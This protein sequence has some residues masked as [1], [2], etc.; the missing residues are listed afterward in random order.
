MKSFYLFICLIFGLVLPKSQVKFHNITFPYFET[1][2]TVKPTNTI[3]ST[4]RLTKKLMQ[5]VEYN[6]FGQQ[7]GVTIIYRNDGSP[8]S[9]NYYHNGKIVYQAIPFQ[10]SFNI[11]KV[12]N[13]NDN[14]NFDGIQSYTYLNNDD[15]KWHQMN[16]T[17]K[18]GRLTSINKEINLPEYIIN[19]DE[20]KLNGN[21]YFYDNINCNCYYYGN[22]TNGKINSI[23]AFDINDD[24]TF[25]ILIYKL[26]NNK[27]NFTK[28]NDFNNPKNGEIEI[29]QN[30]I[31]IENN[32]IKTEEGNSK[33]VFNKQ[34]NW[35]NILNEVAT[36]IEIKNIEIEQI[37]YSEAM[38]GPPAPYTLPSK[39]N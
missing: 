17:F 5:V 12:F 37:D 34:L 25:E 10:N 14:G 38:Y 7:H 18:S 4:N 22:A 36:S 20:G 19:F 35:L 16:F 30:P 3:K 6:Q 29:Y 1:K 24:L 13:Y 8:S 32:T 33:I 26:N 28:I 27:I 31:V 11:Q 15:N 39:K 2:K 21:F 23:G 9:L